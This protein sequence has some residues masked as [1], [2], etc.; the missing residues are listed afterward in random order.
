MNDS[1]AIFFAACVA[2]LIP[3]A[4]VGGASQSASVL[5]I[6]GCIAAMHVV[7][8]G[9]PAF[10][11]LLR[12]KLLR[13]WSVV[14]AGIVCGIIPMAVT[15]WPYWAF[16]GASYTAWDGTKMV[17]HAVNGVPTVSGWWR[18][19]YDVAGIGLLGGVAALG[20]WLAYSRLS[21]GI[22]YVDSPTT[23]RN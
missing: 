8:L 16:E 9:L 15:S 7:F 20:S 23:A 18:Y 10:L 4:L 12:F 11:M 5:L 13:W 3:A 17:E 14:L 1:L 6:A 21:P 19:A 2:V 22:S